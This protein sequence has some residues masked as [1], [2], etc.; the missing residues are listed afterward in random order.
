MT[1]SHRRRRHPRRRPSALKRRMKTPVLILLIASVVIVALAA[2]GAAWWSMHPTTNAGEHTPVSLLVTAPTAEEAAPGVPPS[3]RSRLT[4]IGLADGS[5]AVHRV[6][7]DGVV[8][9]RTVDL[10]PRIDPLDP[11]SPPIRTRERAENA[12]GKVLDAMETDLSTRPATTGGRSLYT[13]LLG[14]DLEPRS[15]LVIIS[16]GLDLKDPLDF[17]RLAFDADPEAVVGA[18]E[19]EGE[20]PR[21]DDVDVTFVVSGTL[22]D[23]P[24]LRRGQLEYVRGVWTA[25]LQRA[26]ASV[27]FV[28]G[29]T[30]SGAPGAPNAP[31]LALPPLGVTPGPEPR[32]CELP[33]SAYFV[34]GESA[35]VGDGAGAAADLARCL[36]GTAPTTQLTLDGWV[37]DTGTRPERDVELSQE[38]VDAVADLLIR[39]LG[40][41]PAR[42]VRRTGHGTRDLPDPDDPASPRNRVVLVRWLDPSEGA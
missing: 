33:S 19:R 17:R 5:V 35:L 23:Q 8:D 20:F 42:I 31:V 26:G 14:L 29:V 25:I 11:T 4:E 7:S 3:V 1:R 24:P 9:S 38:R 22:G 39:E 34:A 2:T 15:R 30:A 27:E 18:L 12:L 6:D 40:V 28:A 32:T 41:D 37:A 13:G 21:L 16:S 10:T 36:K